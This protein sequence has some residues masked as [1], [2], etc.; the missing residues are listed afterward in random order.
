MKKYIA[1]TF[2]KFFWWW[3]C[4]YV[5]VLLTYTVLGLGTALLISYFTN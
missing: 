2:K 1:M 3:I 4:C 5:I